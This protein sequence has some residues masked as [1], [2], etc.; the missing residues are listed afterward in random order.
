MNSDLG[1]VFEKLIL[2][3]EFWFGPLFPFFEHLR[4]ANECH[5]SQNILEKEKNSTQAKV[6]ICSLSPFCVSPVCWRSVK[7][8]S[9][10]A[11][12]EN[13]KKQERR[14]RK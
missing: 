6:A 4:H 5:A 8:K 14:I 2:V 12:E 1:C 3:S 9:S 13:M 10:S 11:R 7:P